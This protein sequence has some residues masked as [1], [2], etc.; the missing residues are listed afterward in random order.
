MRLHVSFI[1]RRDRKNKFQSWMGKC[2]C[3]PA[4]PV[5]RCGAKALVRFVNKKPILPTMEEEENNPRAR[6]AKL[7]VAE[8]LQ[9]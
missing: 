1:G 6:S 3:P 9:V 4:F 5:C 2:I 7:R 8:K